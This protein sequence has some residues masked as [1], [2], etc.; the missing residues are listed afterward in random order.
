MALKTRIQ[1]SR[2]PRR[3]KGPLPTKWPGWSFA[4]ALQFHRLPSPFHLSADHRFLRRSGT[5]LAVRRIATIE[6]AAQ[7]SFCRQSQNDRARSGTRQRTWCMKAA[8]CRRS[9]S[10]AEPVAFGGCC[11]SRRRLHPLHRAT[12]SAVPPSPCYCCARDALGAGVF[13]GAQPSAG[14]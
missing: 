4:A 7:A 12:M 11:R 10:L 6:C 8:S 13:R 14:L 5:S 9:K 1:K 3:G 2:P